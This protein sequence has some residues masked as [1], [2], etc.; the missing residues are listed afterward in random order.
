MDNHNY[1]NNLKHILTDLMV[2][3]FGEKVSINIFNK[4]SVYT[5]DDLYAI[6]Q[7]RKRNKASGDSCEHTF[8]YNYLLS[9][10][11]INNVCPLCKKLIMKLN[12]IN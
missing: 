9:W 1:L 10:R 4:F 3:H 8:C 12:L 11:R 7:K 2:I 5:D 6:C